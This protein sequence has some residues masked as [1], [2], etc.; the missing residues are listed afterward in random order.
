MADSFKPFLAAMGF[1]KEESARLAEKERTMRQLGLTHWDQ[2][3]EHDR[4]MDRIWRERNAELLPIM[5]GEGK[6]HG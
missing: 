3:S 6:A 2:A 4:A 1:V 5:R